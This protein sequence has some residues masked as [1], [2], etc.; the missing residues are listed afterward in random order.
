M[1]NLVQIESFEIL[2]KHKKREIKF[3]SAKLNT[4]TL[5]EDNHLIFSDFKQGF[6]GNCGLMAA[7]AAL[8]QR[9]EF[10]TKIAPTIEQ[11]S[12]GIE[13]KFNMFCEGKSITIKIDDSLPFDEDNALVYATAQR[14]ANL[15]ISSLFEKAFVKQ[16][17]N[18]SY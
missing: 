15:F 3:V 13:L 7:L 17:C 16:A 6:V 10:L 2:E 1:N 5:I 11:T 12:D 4:K 14:K 18:Y 9:S 8:S